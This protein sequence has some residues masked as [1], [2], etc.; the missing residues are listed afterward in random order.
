[1]QQLPDSAYMPQQWPIPPLWNTNGNWYNNMAPLPEWH[2]NM[3]RAHNVQPQPQR[4]IPGYHADGHSG[5]EIAAA[6]A[7]HD[8]VLVGRQLQIMMPQRHEQ[9]DHSA[10]AA[11]TTAPTRVTNAVPVAIAATLA[12][13]PSIANPIARGANTSNTPSLLS[14]KHQSEKAN[15][16]AAS[17][18]RMPLA[19]T[20]GSA[21]STSLAAS[22]G[23]SA[24][25]EP[26]TPAAS[27]APG[28]AMI[29]GSKR[30]TAAGPTRRGQGNTCVTRGELCALEALEQ[31]F[32]GKTF[33][34]VRPEW[35]VNDRTGR[36]LE[37]DLY[38][39]ELRFGL[40]HSG[41]SHYVFPNSLHK[42]REEF[43]AQV[44]RDKL[45]QD[46]CARA[47]VLLIHVPFTVPHAAMQT[48]I[49]SEINRL[50]SD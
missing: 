21:N 25:A 48:Y 13:R 19:P 5:A 6:A 23:P 36:L 14:L 22:S 41:Q 32:P 28:Q 10:A 44:Y 20:A 11:A 4:P 45:K 27:A 29:P 9:I 3:W 50:S 7:A 43:D 38:N 31:I 37:I 30:A 35:L 26:Q 47:G 46:L 15:A 33:E 8:Q 24:V 1:M 12:P 2:V 18:I 40:E 34:K 42:T 39:H 49:R 16:R 17:S